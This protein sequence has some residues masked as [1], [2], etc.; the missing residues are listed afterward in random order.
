MIVAHS[1]DTKRGVMSPQSYK[2]HVINVFMGSRE[3]LETMLT[4]SNLSN[5]IKDFSMDIVSLAAQYHDLGKLDK[6]AQDILLQDYTEEN[7]GKMINHV[8]A[9]VAILLDKYENTKNLAYLSAAFLVHAHHIGL[10][11]LNPMVQESRDKTSKFGIKYLYTPNIKL[12]R[13]NRDIFQTYGIVSNYKSVKEYIDANRG[14]YYQ[15]HLQEIG[16]DYSPLTNIQSKIPLTAIQLRMVFSCLVDADHSDTDRFYSQNYK[17][18]EFEK[19]KCNDRLKKLQKHI[20]KLPTNTASPDRVASRQK[21]YQICSSSIIPSEINFFALDGAVGIGKTLSGLTFLLRLANQRNASRIYNIIP[22]TNIISQT[23]EE[24]RKSI[25]L[26]SEDKNNINEIHSKCEFEKIWMRKYSNL[27]NAPIN[28]STAVQFFESLTSSKTGRTRKLHYF[29]N[30]VFFFDEFDKSIPHSYWKYI[31]PILKDMSENFNCSFVF[32][33]GTSAYY[34][35]I[36]NIDINVHDIIDKDTYQLFKKLEKNR[37]AINIINNPFLTVESFIAEVNREMENKRNGMI[38]CNTI[39]NA[40]YLASIFRQQLKWKIYEMTGW[41]TPEHKERILQKIKDGIKSKEQLLVI[42]T[43]TIE[44]GVNISFEVGWREKCSALNLYQFD[45]RI[46]RDDLLDMAKVYV[47]EWDKSLIGKGNPFTENPQ[48]KAGITVFNSLNKTEMT[49]DKCSYIVEQELF[50]SLSNVA[51]NLSIMESHQQ[52]KEIENEFKVI[53]TATAIIIV[54]KK[55]ITRLRVG[56]RVQYNEIVRKSVQLWID[57]IEKI[58]GL[59]N[60]NVL[61][62]LDDKDYYV[63]EDE[64]DEETGI[65]KIMKIVRDLGC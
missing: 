35:D 33:S 34:W 49:P 31:L 18:F 14:D 10:Q 36:F 16:N 9:G 11:N 61:T 32:S 20:A 17:P 57:K 5:E 44:C 38:V 12:Y 2:E 6:Q 3:R 7:D 54:D 65:G 59:V 1:S 60:I 28:V 4:Y 26:D 45:G 62:T 52:F 51:D 40:S 23:V 42:S 58:E 56:E 50:Y 24:Y 15:I 27:W 19:L 63:W 30:S 46:N 41:Q 48:N 29:A 47:Y 55:L 53:N 43:S 8:D 25:L 64:Y 39:N 22:F 37:V 21:L 13:D